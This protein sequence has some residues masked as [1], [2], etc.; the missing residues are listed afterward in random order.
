MKNIFKLSIVSLAMV[1]FFGCEENMPEYSEIDVPT[2][3]IEGISGSSVVVGNGA[4]EYEYSIPLRIDA[5]Y[6]WSVS[7]DATITPVEGQE[8]KAL[9]VPDQRADTTDIVVSVVETYKGKTSDPGTISVQVNPFCPYDMSLYEGSYTGTEPGIHGP[10]VTMEAT[11]NLNE[12]RVYNLAWFVPNDWGEN[13][14]NGDGSCLMQFVCGDQIIIEPQWIGDSDYPDVYGITGTGTFDPA[15]KTIVLTYD[16]AYS[17]DG[18]GGGWNGPW[19]TT[20]T[21]D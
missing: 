9:L 8:F 14:T 15:T 19:T 7:G 12:L 1:F 4:T 18:S 2:T 13:W 17:W 10:T 3:V 16:V 5:T 6:Q 11:S 20:L 21:M